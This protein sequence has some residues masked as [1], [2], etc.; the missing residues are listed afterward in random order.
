MKGCSCFVSYLVGLII[1]LCSL[2]ALAANQADL[3]KYVLNLESTESKPDIATATIEPVIGKRYEIYTTTISL[4]NGKVFY[5]LRVGFFRSKAEAEVIAHKLRG[6]YPKLWL[7][8]VHTGDRKSL[9]VWVAQLPAIA[10]SS[11]V[12]PV[13]TPPAAAEPPSSLPVAVAP[14][15]EPVPPEPVTTQAVIESAPAEPVPEQQQ[16]EIAVAPQSQEKDLEQYMERAK[17]AMANQQYRVAVGLYSLVVHKGPS[18]FQKQAKEYLGLAR[19]KNGQLIHARA[20]YREYLKLYPEGQDAERVKQRLLALETALLKPKDKLFKR[21]KKEFAKWQFFGTLS[22]YYRDDVLESDFSKTDIAT[23]STDVNLLLRRRTDS[24]NIRTQLTANHLKYLNNTQNDA[25]TS[26]T[27]MYIDFADGLNN[28][29]IRIG[30]QTQNKGGV[31]GRMD[32][33]WMDYRLTSN[34]KVNLV[35][36]YPVQVTVSNI[37]QDN[38]PF[39]GISADFDTE[40]KA[41]SYNLYAIT[42]KVDTLVDRNAVGGEI[43]YQKDK[44][45]HFLSVDY[46]TFYSQLNTFYFVGNWRFENN[47]NFILTLN[48]RNSP[49]LTTTNALVGQTAQSIDEML[50]T[51]TEAE[52]KQLALDRT[53]NYKSASLSTTIPISGKWTFNAEATVSNLSSTPSSGGVTGIASTGDEYFYGIQFI[54]NGVFHRDETTRYEIRYDDTANYARTRYIIN[55]RF[56]LGE[57][58]RIRPRIAWES[59]DNTDGTQTTK[60]A[61][62]M[63]LD[64]KLLRQFKLEFD[65]N[66][67]SAKTDGV[68]P[69]NENNYYISAGFL[70]D[71]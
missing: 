23:V 41:W 16:Q 45:N 58:W 9:A 34:T 26:V 12:S 53:A 4:G 31:I 2:P 54:S 28:K 60:I 55:S 20:E 61:P 47:A 46:D 65:M 63:R 35:A 33:V 19:E 38:R 68:V 43:R 71:F 17:T 44:Q 56:P 69:V 14:V 21:P 7:D 42:Q 66:Y 25:R 67:E 39:Y 11:S 37:A 70:W 50:L 22:Q 6:K 32:G 59:R 1:C 51:Y 18:E 10:N 29:S 13:V 52:I 8:R 48:S 3:Y 36:G 27:N 49:I 5:R 30:R 15:S 57:K 40:A 64:Y 24:Y 62:G